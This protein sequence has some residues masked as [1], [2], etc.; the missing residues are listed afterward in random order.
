VDG[1]T[2]GFF[3]DVPVGPMSPEALVNPGA[4]VRKPTKT[5]AQAFSVL[6]NKYGK[7]L[8]RAGANAAKVVGRSTRP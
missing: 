1:D 6:W 2:N 4:T 3:K 7:K 5:R 8:V